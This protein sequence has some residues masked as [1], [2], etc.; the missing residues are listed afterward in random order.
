MDDNGNQ[1]WSHLVWAVG[2]L[3]A[4]SWLAR[5]EIEES[6]KSPAEM[7]SPEDAER[8]YQEIGELLDDW[9]SDADCETE[10]DYTQDLAD[11]LDNSRLV[12]LKRHFDVRMR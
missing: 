5:N 8:A 12:Q 1:N 10:D 4:G 9:E 3:L 7:E 2:G 11:Y 6:K